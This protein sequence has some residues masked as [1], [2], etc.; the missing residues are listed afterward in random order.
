[1]KKRSTLYLARG[2]MIASLYVALTYLAFILGLSSGAIQLRIS[3]MLC[4]L[5]VFFPEATV[6][7]FLGCLISNLITG[8][9]VWDIIFGAIAT[10]IGAIGAR[11]LRFLPK[12]LMFIATLPT[13]FSNMLIVPLVL[14]YAYG[15]SGGYFY[16]MLTVG[17][18]E[19]ITAVLGG[20]LLYYLLTRYG[21]RMLS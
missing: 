19:F 5:P 4:I 18:G 1:M 3:E 16:F 2:A 17:I 13:L 11:L 21:K 20:T 15:L 8:C 6:G 9:V 12:G 14:I 7:L 10:L